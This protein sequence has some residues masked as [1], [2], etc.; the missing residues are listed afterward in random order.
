MR[1]ALAIE[2]TRVFPREKWGRFEVSR[3]GAVFKNAFFRI[4]VDYPVMLDSILRW[5]YG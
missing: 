2:V 4:S 1:L 3:K 5:C